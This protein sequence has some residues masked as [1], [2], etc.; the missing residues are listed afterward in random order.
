MNCGFHRLHAAGAAHTCSLLLS[1][2]GI[3]RENF[4]AVE[5]A[6]YRRA[7]ILQ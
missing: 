1:D 4:A 2:S 6:G 7:T 3:V 5:F